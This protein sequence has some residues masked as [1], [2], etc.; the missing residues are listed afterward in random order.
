MSIEQIL[1]S[2]P[3]SVRDQFNRL[4]N[5]LFDDDTTE[6]LSLALIEARQ[7]HAEER[8]AADRLFAI[9][10]QQREQIRV[11]RL[12]IE[13]L[14]AKRPEALVAALLAAADL[15]DEF[16]FK[17][18][19]A[20]LADVAMFEREIERASLVL[21]ILQGKLLSAQRALD[22]AGRSSIAA[23]IDLQEHLDSLRLEEA[24]SRAVA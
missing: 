14:Q 6:E 24:R 21:P 8:K 13:T 17:D 12:E 2:E 9:I 4:A 11:Q 1:K 3:A 23:E 7:R 18:D 22:R 16:S 19:D 5:V 15:E 20:I 10:D